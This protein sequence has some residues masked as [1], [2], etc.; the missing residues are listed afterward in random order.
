MT[1]KLSEFT[2]NQKLR[3]ITRHISASA[4][5][6]NHNLTLFTNNLNYQTTNNYNYASSFPI[7][8]I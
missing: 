3:R 1:I 8:I 7:L 6:K 2:C 5:Y 4:S